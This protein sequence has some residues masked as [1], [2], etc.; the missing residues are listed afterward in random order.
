MVQIVTIILFLCK[1]FFPGFGCPVRL[2]GSY[3]AAG[4]CL[5]IHLTLGRDKFQRDAVDAVAQAGRL[6]AVVED[7]S[8]VG[9]G[10]GGPN[11]G[12]GEA[13]QEVG[14]LPDI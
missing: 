10:L 5:T 2:S 13:E 14:L 11:L 7:M 9:V 8:E 3:V 1:F 6:G 4:V 12:T